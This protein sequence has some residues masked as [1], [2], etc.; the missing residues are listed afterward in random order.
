M[1]SPSGAP[2]SGLNPDHHQEPLTM[3]ELTAHGD[4]AHNNLPYTYL[5][6]QYSY[7]VL[8]AEHTNFYRSL[9]ALRFRVDDL[10]NGQNLN[11][12]QLFDRVQSELQDSRVELATSRER[13]EHLETDNSRL[14]ENN[15]DWNCE[16]DP[17]C[18]SCIYH[19]RKALRISRAAEEAA[20]ALADAVNL[21]RMQAWSNLNDFQNE[22][23]H[24]DIINATLDKQV[25]GKEDESYDEGEDTELHVD[26]NAYD[27]DG[28]SVDFI[29]E[30]R[31]NPMVVAE[32]ER[33][34]KIKLKKQ[35]KRE[36]FDMFRAHEEYE[37]IKQRLSA[38]EERSKIEEQTAQGRKTAATETEKGRKKVATETEKGRK[39][40]AKQAHVDDVEDEAFHMPEVEK[41]LENLS[42]QATAEDVKDEA[43]TNSASKT[44]NTKVPQD[45]PV[46]DMS[47]NSSPTPKTE[48]S[49][50][51]VSS[52]PPVTEAERLRLTRIE[53]AVNR[54][55]RL[56][57]EEMVAK[58]MKPLPPKT[59][60]AANTKTAESS[61][62]EKIVSSEPPITEAERLR[63]TRIEAA[64]NRMARLATEEMV[65]KGMKPMP[66]KTAPTAN[67]EA[68]KPT[69]SAQVP[70]PRQPRAGGGFL[71]A[72]L[73]GTG[74]QFKRGGGDG[75]K[76]GQ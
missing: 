57:T 10:L 7:N 55:A 50:P 32:R 38:D 49:S 4:L 24:A 69:T 29:F 43:F 48:T 72:S 47:L 76:A 27:S 14:K 51:V 22:A 53:A 68:T 45:N 63:L 34:A 40:A 3:S 33:I 25:A 52:Q 11:L 60:H 6:L 39:K 56:A 15:R 19:L 66:P 70:T 64:I 37:A 17:A 8:L 5:R 1:A 9:N 67:K 41:E 20:N 18:T 31:C 65:A 75:R 44:P 26:R 61:P 59:A 30:M 21:E 28:E 42:K 54:M 74:V 46:E 2:P 35:S 58:G 36:G 71:G 12:Q 23:A 16:D 62:N 73:R 13:I